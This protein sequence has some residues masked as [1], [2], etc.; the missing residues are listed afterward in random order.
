MRWVKLS[1][2]ILILF[3]L[4]GCLYPNAELEKNQIP[5]QI[6]L[7]TVQNAVDQFQEKQ[8]GLLPI[9]T[10]PQDTPI[11]QKYQL[12]FSKLQQQALMGEL[13]GT[14]FENGGYYQYVIIHPETDPTVKVLD[15]RTT[16]TLRSLQVKVTFYQDEHQFPPFGDQIA[17]GVYELDYE[18]L[19]LQEEPFIDSPYSDKMLPVYLN[20]QGEV[21][22]DYRKDLYAYLNE[23]DHQYQPGQDIRY[24][25]TDH[26]PFVPG[27]SE[28][29]T[30]ENGE[31]IFMSEYQAS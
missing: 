30:V 29:Y 19:G 15:L 8:N 1:S 28:E 22:I 6:Q 10:K 11:F 21:L 12:D 27:Y 18:E 13:P 23:Q 3:F 31:P 17:K 2:L 7:E 5:N 4:S 25:L 24:L 26:A 16:E 9:K 14:S 20:A